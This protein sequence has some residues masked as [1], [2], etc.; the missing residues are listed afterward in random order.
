MAWYGRF[1]TVHLVPILLLFGCLCSVY[2]ITQKLGAEIAHAQHLEELEARAAAGLDAGTSTSKEAP[3]AS[4]MLALPHS[5]E[6][7]RDLSLRLSQHLRSHPSSRFW[8]IALFASIYL[9]KQTFSVPGS[10]LLNVMAG[11]IFGSWSGVPLV[12]FLTASGASGAYWLSSAVGRELLGPGAS[13][14][15]LR[16]RMEHMRVIVQKEQ[17]QGN[18][19]LYLTS[20]RLFP[21]SPNWLINLASPLVGVPF[22]TFFFSCLIG[23]TPYCYFSVSG[24]DVLHRFTVLQQQAASNHTTAASM[25]LSDILDGWTMLKLGLL[26]VALLVPTILKRFVLNKSILDDAQKSLKL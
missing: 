11:F 9:L 19:F 13:C 16:T 20:M 4:E 5:F 6:E 18:L 15:G 7:A 10:I 23:L 14:K 22:A 2:L 8:L 3:R 1:R 21:M 12:A 17:A 24:G 25:T 26:A